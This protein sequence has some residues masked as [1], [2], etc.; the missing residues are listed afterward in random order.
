MAG[1]AAP[2]LKCVLNSHLEQFSLVQ[3]SSKR[4]GTLVTVQ[5]LKGYGALGVCGVPPQLTLSA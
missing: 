2:S 5:L 3:R 1:C 4:D